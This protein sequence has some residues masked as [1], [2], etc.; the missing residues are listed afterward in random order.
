MDYQQQLSHTLAS[1]E[2]LSKVTLLSYNACGAYM[3]S[4]DLLIQTNHSGLL[5]ENSQKR[6]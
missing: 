1:L 4:H 6:L 2:W 3:N 5:E